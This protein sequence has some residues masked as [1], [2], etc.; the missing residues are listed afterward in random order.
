MSLR[1]AVLLGLVV[2]VGCLSAA[3]LAE[4]GGLVDA[5]GAAE[6]VARGLLP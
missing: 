4:S 2:F 5:V 1:N 6:R 3:A